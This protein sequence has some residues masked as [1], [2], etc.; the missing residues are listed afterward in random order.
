MQ[1]ELLMLQIQEFQSVHAL[2]TGNFRTFQL[3]TNTKLI[4][5]LG[6]GLGLSE[7]YTEILK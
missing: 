1:V 6:F 3:Y 2:S 5:S 4:E 7:K